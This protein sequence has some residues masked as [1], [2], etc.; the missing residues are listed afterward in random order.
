MSS[1][2]A[3]FVT[4]A[5]QGLGHAIA[6]G[7]AADGF[8][9]VVTELRA[10]ELGRTVQ[11]IEAKGRR[12][13]ALSLDVRDTSSIDRAWSCAFETFDA[14]DV[15]VNN[16][17]VQSKKQVVDVTPEDWDE[18]IG[19]NLKGAYFMSQR[20]GRHLIARRQPGSVISLSSTFGVLGFAERS[21]YGISKGGIAQMTRMLAI[22]WAPHGIRVNAIGPGTIETES[23]AAALADPNVR[24]VMLKRIPL[25]RFGLPDEVA[26]T[27]RYLVS[28][29]GAYVSGQ[30]L[31]LDG[32]LS[33]Q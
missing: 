33:A 27:V 14:I 26:G 6:V 28:P 2:K 19:V 13:L 20:L 25:G 30:V 7:L 12:A 8:D 10:S 3:A 4:G 16:A 1:S 32:A 5:S 29:A 18:V 22:E 24:E 31:M 9:V 21:I 23:R 11:A 17:G 15:L